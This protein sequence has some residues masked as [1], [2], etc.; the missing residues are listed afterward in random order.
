M[1]YNSSKSKRGVCI[2]Y[3]A[4]LDIEVRNVF[5]SPCENLILLDC[6]LNNTPITIG[7]AYGPTYI[8]NPI[9]ITEVKSEIVKLGNKSFIIAGDFNCIQNM[10]PLIRDKSDIT[11]QKKKYYYINSEILNTGMINPKTTFLSTTAYKNNNKKLHTKYFY[12]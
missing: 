1:F 6:L 3:K 8:D 5:K 9:F 4:N 11:S 12:L 10:I 2:L 7:S